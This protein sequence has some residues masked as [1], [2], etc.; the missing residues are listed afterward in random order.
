LAATR[1]AARTV[2][3]AAKVLRIDSSSI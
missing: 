1:A 2:V 3:A